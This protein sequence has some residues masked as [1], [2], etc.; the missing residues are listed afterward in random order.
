M[1]SDIAF[2]GTEDEC[3]IIAAVRSARDVQDICIEHDT[4][5][6]DVVDLYGRYLRHCVHVRQ[7]TQAQREIHEAQLDRLRALVERY[8]A[9]AMNGEIAA[10]RLVLA[11]MTAQAA[12]EDRAARWELLN[13]ARTA[14]SDIQKGQAAGQGYE[15]HVARYAEIERVCQQYGIPVPRAVTVAYVAA[16]TG[17]DTGEDA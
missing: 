12:Q 4:T 6:E 8:F 10:A 5:P 15:H 2:P 9:R 14:G 3:R 1:I 7:G 16:L 11:A 13:A 17:S